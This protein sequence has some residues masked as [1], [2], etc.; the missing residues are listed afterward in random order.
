MLY[1][2]NYLTIIFYKTIVFLQ[3]SISQLN[4]LVNT[5]LNNYILCYFTI[6]SGPY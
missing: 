5:C 6:S 1:E 4:K 3:N 2:Y